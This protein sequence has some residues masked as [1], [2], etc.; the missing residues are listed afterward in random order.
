MHADE[1]KVLDVEIVSSI[2]QADCSDID[3]STEEGN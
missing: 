2:L 1:K 3:Q